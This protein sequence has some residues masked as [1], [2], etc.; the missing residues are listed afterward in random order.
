MQGMWDTVG[1]LGLVGA[2]AGVKELFIWEFLDTDLHDNTLAAYHA[3][4]IDE[5]RGEFVLVPW[6]RRA[7]PNQVLEQVW[8][9]G[10]H[11]DVG[12]SA[13]ELGTGVHGVE[14]KPSPLADITLAWML[15]HARQCGVQLTTT[16]EECLRVD[17]MSAVSPSRDP[18]LA[19]WCIGRH[20]NIPVDALIA[21][22]VVMRLQWDAT[23]RPENLALTSAGTLAC[24]RVQPVLG[25]ISNPSGPVIPSPSGLVIP[26]DNIAFDTGFTIEP[27]V[28]YQFTASGT[29]VDLDYVASPEGDPK[30]GSRRF[31]KHVKR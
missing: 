7:F 18:F 12:G 1:A 9:S 31:F 3:M 22:S 30:A 28:T 24:Y 19:P 11:A 13:T 14:A 5:H 17:P 20:R 29:W 6:Q 16:G 25:A 23:Y 4:A 27:G 26:S 8:F 21:D 15:G 2:L 10:V